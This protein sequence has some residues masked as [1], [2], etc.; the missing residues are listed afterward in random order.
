MP[1]T[2]LFIGADAREF[3]GFIPRWQSVNPL[4]LPVNW[5]RSGRWRGR[6][7]LAIANGA[8]SER[9]F[10][11]VL[12]AQKASAICNIGFCGALHDAL[13]IGDV[14]VGTQVQ[15][16]M[17][18][19]FAKTPHQTAALRGPV[20]SIDR[21]AQTAAEKQRLRQTGAAIVEMDAAGVARAAEDLAVPFYCIRAVSD[22]ANE[23]FSTDFNRALR[24]DGSFSTARLVLQLNF[25]ELLQ[26]RRR[27]A[28]ASKNLGE[29]LDAA[30]F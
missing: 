28:L 27:T 6:E 24:P 30:D 29:F 11:A 1:D 13:H 18:T 15:T 5:A 21:V 16:D 10:A 7:V 26:L 23:T 8:G 25:G 12:M 2:L 9:A 3:A 4:P 17:R 20:M 14:V 22:L 19:W